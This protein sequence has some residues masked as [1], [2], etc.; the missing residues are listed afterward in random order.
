MAVY[1]LTG[2]NTYLPPSI[3]DP[4]S[5]P[6]TN[7]TN[8][9]QAVITVTNTDLLDVYIVGQLCYL[10]VPF[11]YG[12]FQANALTVEIIEVNGNDFTVQL[13]TTQFD[14]WTSPSGLAQPATLAPAGSRNIYN[15]TT[16]PFHSES[17]TGN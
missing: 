15:F 10:S 4:Q 14:P 9:V 17:N 3:V 6:I 1:P 12:M 2:S 7:I 5:L 11:D 8:A 13:D 16:L